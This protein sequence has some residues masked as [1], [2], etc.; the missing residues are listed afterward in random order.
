MVR[1]SLIV[2]ALIFPLFFYGQSNF[3]VSVFGSDS[4]D[5]AQATPFR[6]IQYAI[7]NSGEGDTIIVYGGSY[8]EYLNITHDDITIRKEWPED[9]VSVQQPFDNPNAEPILLTIDSK[10]NVTITGIAFLN[11]TANSGIGILIKGNS[12]NI[13]IEDAEIS[14]INFSSSPN[15]IVN[16]N[17]NAQPI[18]IFGDHIDPIEN[19]IIRNCYIHDC[20]IGYS[21][22]LALNGNVANFIIEN[23]TIEDLTNIAIDAIGHEG[24]CPDPNLDQARNGIIRGNTISSCLS[25]YATS[26]AIYVDGGKDILIE[27]NY[28]SHN[29]Y[30]I[31]VGCEHVGKS[32]E[33]III[34]NNILQDN[35]VAGLAIGGYDYPNNSGT[36]NNVL[37]RN[38]TFYKNDY[39]NDFTGEFLMTHCSNV[40]IANNIFFLNN[41][42]I[43][44]YAENNGGNNSMTS[45][46]I[47]NPL[48]GFEL[49]WFD[50]TIEEISQFESLLNW[51][52]AAY[53][54]SPFFVSVSN[55]NFNLNANSNAIGL[56]NS[57]SDITPDELDYYGNP[58][59]MGALDCGAAEFDET[60][61]TSEYQP[62]EYSVF[63]N[64]ANFILN[65]NHPHTRIE[66]YDS[67]GKR[68]F[69]DFNFQ[70]TQIDVSLWRPGLY[71]FKV[72]DVVE[73]II[74]EH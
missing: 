12:K 72:G 46:L 10:T 1:F 60:N 17:T 5:G 37:V 34:K 15:P 16:E 29:G 31:E 51:T 66:I 68:V 8:Y 6:S 43:L 69:N 36:V 47:W 41:Q 44:G 58:R 39:L 13:L 27:R 40:Q 4:N 28:T 11:L 45:N 63:P 21:E 26:A 22:G 48:G 23:N 7:D 57:T 3:Y 70:K 54:G 55:Q 53:L 33:N 30:G 19:I 62:N 24:T 50:Q 14:E 49:T 74:I 73:K 64:P 35:E 59:I 42:G 32:A 71:F 65:L 25:E 9:Q 67:L 18:I 2:A 52:N 56:A 61:Q 38:N 20:T